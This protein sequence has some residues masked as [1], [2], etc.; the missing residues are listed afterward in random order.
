MQ[1]RVNRLFKKDLHVV[2]TMQRYKGAACDPEPDVG[3][4]PLSEVTD[5]TLDVSLVERCCS[6]SFGNFPE[7]H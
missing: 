5:K 6:S 1:G 3:Q 4:T 2:E 7:C